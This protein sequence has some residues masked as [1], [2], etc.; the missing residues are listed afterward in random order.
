M[1]LTWHYS[2]TGSQ[3]LG[4]LSHQLFRLCIEVGNLGVLSKVLQDFHH[5]EEG[6]INQNR[7]ACYLS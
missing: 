5:G 7:L 4:G 3:V 6:F 2:F 1:S